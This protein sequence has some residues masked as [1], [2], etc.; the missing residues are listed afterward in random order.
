MKEDMKLVGVG[1][2]EDRDGEADDYLIWPPKGT[3]RR[4]RRI[5]DSLLWGPWQNL[6]EWGS[7]DKYIYRYQ[8]MGFLKLKRSRTTM[9]D[10][11]LFIS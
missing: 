6:F 5:Q 7:A 10:N 11:C 3:A 4:N 2:E 9:L 1:E 8:F